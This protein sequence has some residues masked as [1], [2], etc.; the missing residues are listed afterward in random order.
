MTENASLSD[1]ELESVAEGTNS[2][3]RNRLVERDIADAQ[4]EKTNAAWREAV[5]EYLEADAEYG[6]VEA[7][8]RGRFGDVVERLRLLREALRQRG[9]EPMTQQTDPLAATRLLEG[10]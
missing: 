7:D 9:V 10:S 5:R 6:R 8:V 4:H 1:E 3:G 2:P